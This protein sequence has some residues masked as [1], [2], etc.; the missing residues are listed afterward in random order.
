[1]KKTGV[2]FFLSLCL[3]I[4]GCN[5][6]SGKTVVEINGKKITE[7]DLAFLSTLNPNI[8]TQLATPFGKK[9]ILDNLVEQELLY[10]AAKKEGL[11]RKQDVKNKIDLYGKVILAQA[12]VEDS[13]LKEA[14]KYYDANKGEFERL[15]LSQIMVRYATPEEMKAARKIKNLNVAKHSEPDALKIANE[16][17]DKLKG[18][19]D[20]AKLA[21]ETSEDPMTKDQGGDLGYVSKSD[22]KLTR[23]GFE[24]LI[25]KA[26][27][28]KVGEIAGPIK[29]TSG[30]SIITVTAPAEQAPFE[31]VKNQVLF[32]T[33]GDARTKLL[34]ELKEK[35]KVVYAKEFESLEAPQQP[36]PAKPA[37]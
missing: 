17:Y 2:L 7:G 28:M 14:K 9:Q 22:P 37:N 31:E 10:Q 5:S 26:Y 4:S 11:D 29:T 15:K 12:F 36:V 27:T 32:K 6:S 30:Y 25:E 35:N 18:G 34:T 16:I 13:S 3:M 19:E 24:P 20:F 21:K 8:A 33:R 1:M 23:R